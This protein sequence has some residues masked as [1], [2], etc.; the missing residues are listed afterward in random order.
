MDWRRCG[1]GQLHCPIAR[2]APGIDLEE[3]GSVEATDETILPPGDA[4][5]V[6]GRAHE[7]LAFPLGAASSMA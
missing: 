4:E 3:A 6:V 1:V 7:G 5:L 2:L